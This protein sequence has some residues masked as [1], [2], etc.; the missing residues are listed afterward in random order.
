MIDNYTD[1][2]NEVEAWSY[3]SDLTDRIPTFVQLCESDLQVRCKLV[4]FENDANVAVTSGVGT[5]PT[6]YSQARAVFWEGDQIRS[7]KYL[8]PDQMQAKAYLAGMPT[9]YTITGDNIQVLPSG[10]GTLGMTYKARF[11]A[12]SGTNPTNVILTRYPEAYLHGTLA[13][14][15]MYTK[16]A[17]TLTTAQAAYESAI[18]RIKLDNN[19]RKYGSSLEVRAR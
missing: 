9:Y 11:S 1:L 7:L 13:Q 6:D 12:L 18:L 17:D 4:D 10:D 8:T 3:R 5:L 14:L 15:A 2:L 16:D 19:Q